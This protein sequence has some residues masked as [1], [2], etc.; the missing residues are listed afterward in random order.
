M[1]SYPSVVFNFYCNTGH[2]DCA[3]DCISDRSMFV[4]NSARSLI[5][6][7]LIKQSNW[8]LSQDPEETLHSILNDK[9]LA[10]I[11][12]R[13]RSMLSQESST[14][15]LCAIAVFEITR[16]LLCEDSITGKRLLEESRMFPEYLK[17]LK[18]GDATVCQRLVDVLCEIA[19]NTRY[20]IILLYKV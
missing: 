7:Y 12:E 5:A 1:Y 3:W 11:T 14:F 10:A 19:K 2:V 15:P 18:D 20:I 4:A 9:N 16:I 8:V 17:V 13:M 6:K